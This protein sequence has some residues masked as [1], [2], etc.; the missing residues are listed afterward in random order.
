MCR[1]AGEGADAFDST[2]GMLHELCSVLFREQLG[3]V[4]GVD[5]VAQYD[6]FNRLVAKHRP[7]C[8]HSIKS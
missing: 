5:A 2:V 3:F 1:L 6:C 8:A 4:H 7:R